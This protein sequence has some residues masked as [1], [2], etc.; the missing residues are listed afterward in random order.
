MSRAFVVGAGRCGT[1]TFFHAA[2]TLIGWTAGHETKAG[3]VALPD[4]PDNHVEVDHELVWAIPA[5]RDRYPRALWVHLVRDREP[6]VESLL[7]E[8]WHRMEAWCFSTFQTRFPW[9]V[10]KAPALYYD[11]TTRLIEAL[12][13]D[14]MLIRIETLREQ[15]PTFCARLGAE[16]DR[17]AAE[18]I[19]P[20]RY[21]PGG[22]RGRDYYL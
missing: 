8:N 9:D 12:C 6:C 11:L 5:I 19:F 17:V 15:W 21:N 7:R 20:R 10:C 4:Y 22:N 3:R 1:S 2:T 13:P 18:E 16:W 14:A